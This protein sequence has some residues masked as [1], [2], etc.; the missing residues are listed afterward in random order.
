MSMANSGSRTGG[1]IKM[2]IATNTT[3]T[4]FNK[5]DERLHCDD[6]PVNK[7]CE[8]I[9]NEPFYLMSKKQLTKNFESYQN[10]VKDLDYEFIGY[11]VRANQNIHILRY[12][13][14]M[15]CGAI[16]STGKEFKTCM[17]AG[18]PFDKMLF[19]GAGKR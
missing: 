3:S 5:K 9:D 4:G 2:Q 1:D 19:K 8:S 16:V 18:F 6:L 7:I 12:L 17:Q 11:N 14:E 13:V 10:Q 15:G